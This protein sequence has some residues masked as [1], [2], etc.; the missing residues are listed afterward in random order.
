[1]LC[2]DSELSV[3]EI[4]KIDP[5]TDV[6][7]LGGNALMATEVLHKLQEESNLQILPCNFLPGRVT[8]RSHHQGLTL[9]EGQRP[10]AL[11]NWPLS[12][13]VKTCNV[14]DL[15]CMCT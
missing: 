13:I 7:Q 6:V 14:Q 15:Q 3:T 12:E 8:Q 11:S 9:G 4:N 5:N 2:S 10:L 1:M